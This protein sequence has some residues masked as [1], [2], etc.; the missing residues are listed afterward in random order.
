MV[1]L[2]LVLIVLFMVLI[3]YFN[4]REEKLLFRLSKMI[5]AANAGSLKVT[6]Y[7]ETQFSSIENDLFRFLTDRTTTEERLRQ[8]KNSVQSLI[9]DISHQTG[10]PLAN[11]SLY[12]QLL[13]EKYGDSK[14][15]SA[16]RR[17]SEKLDFLIKALIKMSRL[18]NGIIQ[19]NVSQCSLAVLLKA[20]EEAVREKALDKQ[21]V[22]V[23]E[24]VDDL[25]AIFDLKWTT[26]ALVNILENA[27]KYSLEFGKIIVKAESY[28][29]F[30]RITISDNGIGIREEEQNKIF[31][32]FYRSADVR[33]KEGIGLGLYLTRQIIEAQKGY[34]RV[35]STLNKGSDFSVFLP[36]K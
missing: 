25:S 6:K 20:V 26:E 5:D 12:S 29:L 28:S 19:P 11:I 7:S 22:I 13:E 27:I 14:E 2:L 21:I 4:K 1:K 18:E 32:R 33:E 31:Q 34:I 8:Q 16:L 10:T 30:T 35:Q 15:V 24:P 23:Y 9:A 36:Q 3:I 17:Q